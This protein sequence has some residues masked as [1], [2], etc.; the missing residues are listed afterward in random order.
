MN[1][2]PDSSVWAVALR[3]R[4]TAIRTPEERS[5]ILLADA[6]SEGRVVMIGP[7]RQELLS[8]IKDKAH[9]AKLKYSLEA[10]RDE[11]L[12]SADY[13]EAARFYRL[14][15]ARGLQAGPVDMLICAAA[16][17]R[18]WK[19]LTNDASLKERMAVIESA[20]VPR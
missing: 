10:F 18:N 11:P 14:C 2:L 5:T 1:L 13:E 9:F 7:I 8:G 19:V 4:K 3:R 12:E 6:I 16:A 20:A 15:R 17:R